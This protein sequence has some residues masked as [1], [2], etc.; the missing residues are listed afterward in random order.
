MEEIPARRD[1]GNRFDRH[2]IPTTPDVAGIA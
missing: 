1:Y 2:R